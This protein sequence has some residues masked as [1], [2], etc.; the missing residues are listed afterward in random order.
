MCYFIGIEDLV[1]NAL[2]EIVESSGIR[3]V[4]FSQL[5]KYGDVIL[6]KLKETNTEALL[7]LNRDT[8]NKFFHDCS[9]IFEIEE[10]QTDIHITLKDNISTTVLRERFRINIALHLL[11]A[12]ISTEAIDVLMGR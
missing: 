8:T 4:K 9:D 6:T 7:V 12:F 10:T 11:K 5:N 3:T 1:A 2:I